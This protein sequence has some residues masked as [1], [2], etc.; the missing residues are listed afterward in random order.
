MKCVVVIG[1]NR[2]KYFEKVVKSLESNPESQTLPFFFFLDGGPKSQQAK[3][4]EIIEKHK[5]PLRT[6]INRDRNL[7]C[8]LNIIDA[9]EHVFDH[10]GFDAAMIFEDDMIVSPH[11]IHLGFRLLRQ[12]PDACIQ[13]WNKCIQSREWKIK[14]LNLVITEK[15]HF[16][17]YGMR[18][19]TWD[20]ISPFLKEYRERFLKGIY[21]DR[22]HGEI[23]KWFSSL[24]ENPPHATGQDAATETALQATKTRRIITMVNRGKYIGKEG[25]HLTSIRYEKARFGQVNLDIFP[26]DQNIKEFCFGN[27]SDIKLEKK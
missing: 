25:I 26:E 15:A 2:P 21:K 23:R 9:R 7:G 22:P 14:R 8:G 20:R 5:F 3:Y 16:W 10:L 27:K 12:F 17:G 4:N 19:Q 11:Y 6:I 13:G 24:V 1:Y 18:K